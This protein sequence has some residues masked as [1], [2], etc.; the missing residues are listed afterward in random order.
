VSAAEAIPGHRGP[1]REAC[2]MPLARDVP[3]RL[4]AHR[5]ARENAAETFA[6]GVI[7]DRGP[8]A[9]RPIAWVA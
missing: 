1:D 7:F 5:D 6:V 9:L 8:A 2:P 3:T 4:A